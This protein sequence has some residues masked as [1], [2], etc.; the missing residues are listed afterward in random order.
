MTPDFTR[1]PNCPTC[2]ST[3][4]RARD[5]EDLTMYY[6][7]PGESEEQRVTRVDALLRERD[8]R[9]ALDKWTPAYP[10]LLLLICVG[11]PIGVL[12]SVLPGAGTPSYANPA[13]FAQLYSISSAVVAYF[14]LW[15]KP[16]A[17]V[18][19]ESGVKAGARWLWRAMVYAVTGRP[20]DR[21]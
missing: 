13:G 8:V 21:E 16:V 6:A 3:I 14:S 20:I 15:A 10:A 7:R 9:R 4:H 11:V 12:S 17:K 18:W 2:G 5:N 1:L 19:R